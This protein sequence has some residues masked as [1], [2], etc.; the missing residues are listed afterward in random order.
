MAKEIAVFVGVDGNTASFYEKG[1]VIVFQRNQG[2]W[3]KLREKGFTLADSQGMRGLREKMA[4]VV[5][6]L[7][8]CRIFIGLS[9]IGVPYFELEKA[10]CS[11]W[12]FEG[13]PL[14]F[15]DYI[16]EQEEAERA[17]K[18][19]DGNPDTEIKPIERSAGCFYISLKDIQSRNLGITSKQALLPFLRKG[20]FYELEVLCDHVPPWLEGELYSSGLLGRIEKLGNGEIRVTITKKCSDQC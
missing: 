11:I 14:E 4:E 13:N 20:S 7:G 1:K 3:K 19:R 5:K 8:T 12:E 16:L 18:T 2:K 15:L 17:G 10:G 6:F 9:V